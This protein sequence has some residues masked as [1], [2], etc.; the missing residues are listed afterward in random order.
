MAA[1]RLGAAPPPRRRPAGARPNAPTEALPAKRTASHE[2]SD[3]TRRRLAAP[4]DPAPSPRRA[5]TARRG[6]AATDGPSTRAAAPPRA[7]TSAS[8]KVS[9]KVGAK[10]G[11]RPSS[12][13]RPGARRRP[14]PARAATR[15]RPRKV[16]ARNQRQR[17]RRT[18]RARRSALATRFAAG[19]PRLRLLTTL[20]VMLLCL[21]AVLFKV[22]LLQTLQGDA[23]RSAAAQQ[24][25]R[26]RTLL[27]QR[28]TIFDRNG[29][30]LALSVPAATV[31][32]NPKQVQDPAATAD[33]LARVLDLTSERERDLEVAMAKRDR[34]FLYVA[35]QV[36]PAL[37]EELQKLEL[38]GLTTYREDRRTFPG[39]VTARS[40]IGRTDIDGIGI[41]G[42]ED[43]YDKVLRGTN[44]EESLEVAPDG[45]SIP[46]S[47][48][49]VDAPVAGNDVILTIDRSVQYAVEQALLRRS[50]ETRARGGQAIVMD[51]D[52]GEIIAMASVR[53]N[54]DGEYEVT[55]GN[56]SAVDAYEPGSVGKVITIS[57]ALNE[58]TVTPES[59]F[60]VPWRKQ[61]TRDG[62]FLHDSHVHGDEMMSVE[63]IL[64]AS[65][66]IGTITVSET[67]GFEKQYNY[68]RAFGLGEVT[69]LD[70]PQESPGILH[71]WQE[72]EGTE[73]YTVA[74]GQGVASTPIQLISAVNVVANDGR[75]VDP[76]LVMGTVD[77][78]GEV[79]PTDASETRE[80]ISE[81]AATQMQHMMREVVC[82]GTAKQAQVPGLS[83][84]GKTGTGFIAQPDGTYFLPDGS[85][86]YYASFVGFLPAEDPQVTILV[87]ID[88]P[89]S[90]SGDRFGGTASAPVFRTLA[91]IMVHE[92]GIEPPAGST[93]CEGAP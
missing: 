77:A 22:G 36:D 88:Q 14:P 9:A 6:A 5:G 46:G 20:V 18:I 16:R 50:A 4:H 91:P 24:W 72:W 64:V 8:A 80:V 69:A 56:H 12:S 47:E 33:A 26:D 74:Y 10:V 19:Q 32:V 84:A 68:M 2:A 62:N 34:G 55:S 67:M 30:E 78:D 7:S 75:Y 15:S 89:D 35:R 85:H 66:N 48:R 52:S 51:T 17:A 1:R 90:Q 43:Q 79:H 76:K 82:R 39:G 65:S 54:D 27:A 37:A 70:F 28:G 86:A 45:R 61:Y 53:I 92:L 25:T 21:M 49:I 87:S 38:P 31:A 42:L 29:D 41:A 83:V 40:V 11:A 58:G 73:K 23:L 3:P 60:Y 93:G 59:T 13:S 44:G 57:G 63:Q 81:A 71:P